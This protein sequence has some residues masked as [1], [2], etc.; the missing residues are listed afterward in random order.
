MA[1]RDGGGSRWQAIRKAR[2]WPLIRSESPGETAG[3]ARSRSSVRR[4]GPIPRQWRAEMGADHGGRPFAR[5][6]H[7]RLYDLNRLVKLLGKL[8]HDHP[9]DGWGQ[10]LDNGAPRWGR[11]TVAGHSQGAGMAAYT[12]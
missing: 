5:R 2:A 11:I 9:S 4:V 6:G 8:D 10:Y 1:R 7:G 12:I 3:Q